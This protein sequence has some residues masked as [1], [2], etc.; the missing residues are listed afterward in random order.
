MLSDVCFDFV[1][2]HA[3]KRKEL[4]PNLQSLAESVEHYCKSYPKESGSQID[5]LRRAIKRV[6]RFYRD[7][8]RP[9]DQDRFEEALLWL[10]VLAE[11]VRHYYDGVLLPDA[12]V[13]K[14]CASQLRK[15]EDIEQ[16]RC[17]H[18][19]TAYRR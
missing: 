15:L 7:I 10:F 9:E 3:Q 17:P 8:S 16:G 19:R 14:W 11:T 13:E 4:I 5:A 2:L 1:I 6:E 12:S 18:C